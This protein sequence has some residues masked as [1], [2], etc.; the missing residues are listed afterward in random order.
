[1]SDPGAPAFPSSIGSVDRKAMTSN[2]EVVGSPCQTSS[3][4]VSGATIQFVKVVALENVSLNIRPGEFVSIVGPSGCGK[5]TLLNYIAG[6]LPKTVLTEG[7][8]SLLGKP[9]TQGNPQVSYML[10][11]DS[12]LPWRTVLQNAEFGAEG[13]GVSKQE[14]RQDASSLLKRVGLGAFEAAYPKMLS[15]GMRQRVALARTFCMKTPILLMDEPFGALDVQTKM[16]LA[17]LL[18]ELWEETRRTVIFIT[19]DL[20]EAITLGDRVIVMSPRPGRVT[21][22]VTIDLPR[23]RRINELQKDSAFHH[24]YSTIWS[25]LEKGFAI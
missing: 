25:Q 17:E 3:V 20:G 14:R 6:L 16:Q 2:S 15:N 13:R 21:A 11:R 9:P 24:L 7:S 19:H 18:L 12:L 22:D 8:V 23:P 1:M 4:C 10:A 5:T